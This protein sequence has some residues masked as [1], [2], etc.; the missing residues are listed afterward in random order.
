DQGEPEPLDA[1]PEY[2]AVRGLA[3]GDEAERALEIGVGRRLRPRSKVAPGV[4]LGEADRVEQP[5][6]IRLRRLLAGCR[7]GF[8]AFSRAALVWGPRLLFLSAAGLDQN[9]SMD[10]RETL[11]RSRRT[12][13]APG[14]RGQSRSPRR[15]LSVLEEDAVARVDAQVDLV[16]LVH[17]IGRH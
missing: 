15:A 17:R 6:I 14:A 2:L 9:S 8:L 5:Q 11:M 4:A 3:L 10:A 13:P 1:L 16:V 7:H 12:F